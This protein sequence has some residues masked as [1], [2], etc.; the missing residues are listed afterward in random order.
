MRHPCAALPRRAGRARRL[1]A[2]T[3]VALA[4]SAPGAFAERPDGPSATRWI[5]VWGASPQQPVDPVV[6]VST[7]MTLDGQTIREVVRISA[8]AG[9]LRLRLTNE[10][11][12]AATVIGSV[13][14][15]ISTAAGSA[16]SGV[17]ARTDRAVTFGG[18]PG[19]TLAPNAPALSDPIDL[20]VPALTSLAVSIYVASSGAYVTPHSEGKQTAFIAAGDQTGAASLP[21]AATTTA[22]YVLSG[23]DGESY[24]GAATIVTLGDSIT[25]GT[26]STPDADHRWPDYLADRLQAAGFY[27]LAVDDQ[28]IAGDR[29]RQEGIGPNAQSRFDRDVLSRPGVRFVTVLEGINDIG[30]PLLL[31]GSGTVASAAEIVAADKQLIGRAHER[32]LLIYGAT[33]TP[34]K[35]AGY[36]SDAGEAAREAVNAWIRG[37]GGFDGLIDFDAAV[38]DPS[39]PLTLRA[40]YDSGDHLHPSDAGYKAM[41]RSIDL[42]LFERE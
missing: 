14:V 31:P 20:S 35:G 34:F 9:R 23:V 15:A 30:I 25:D 19:V 3:I 11:T 37:P 22:R 28:G 42:G 16:G 26:N 39:D 12:N 8:G 29:L 13:H 21:G 1:A 33:L 41:A 40:A 18:K 24:P 2:A 4:A 36:Y 32:G 38:R 27:G 7:P 17:R 5:E 10:Y 6:N